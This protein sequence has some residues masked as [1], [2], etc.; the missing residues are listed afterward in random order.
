MHFRAMGKFFLADPHFMRKRRILSANTCRNFPGFAVA[1]G[2]GKT[3][4]DYKYTD[5][6]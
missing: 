5:Y 2:Q 4:D 1:I 3:V 6:E